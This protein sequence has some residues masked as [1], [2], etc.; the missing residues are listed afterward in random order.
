MNSLAMIGGGGVEDMKVCSM[1]I[2]DL[3]SVH[4]NFLT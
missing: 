4:G 2:W 1:F 3:R